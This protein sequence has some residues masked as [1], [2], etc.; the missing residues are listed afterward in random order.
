MNNEQEPCYTMH[1]T[2]TEKQLNDQSRAAKKLG[3]SWEKWAIKA[4]IKASKPNSYQ[5]VTE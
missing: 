4:L 1:L 3:L 5:T 2:I